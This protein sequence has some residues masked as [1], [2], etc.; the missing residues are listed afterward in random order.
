MKNRVKVLE[1]KVATHQIKDKQL[2]PWIKD[3]C[4][5][6]QLLRVRDGSCCVIIQKTAFD[7]TALIL[8]LFIVFLCLC[9]CGVLGTLQKVRMLFTISLLIV[10][11]EKHIISASVSFHVLVPLPGMSFFF[12][13][14]LFSFF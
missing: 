3:L 13:F 2:D 7:S 12:F 11:S 9:L 6:P 5:Q 4:R 8:L 10:P 14:F 1:V